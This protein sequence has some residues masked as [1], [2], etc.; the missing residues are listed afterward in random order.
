MIDQLLFRVGEF[1]IEP[2]S[3][4]LRRR[5][6]TTIHLAS[7]SFQALL[8]LIVYEDSLTRCLSSVRKAI[9]DRGGA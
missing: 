6:G 9:A 4:R 8:Y 1:E 7:R 2:G 3:R 5:D